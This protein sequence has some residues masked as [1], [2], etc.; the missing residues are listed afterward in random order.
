[1]TTLEFYAISIALLVLIAAIFVAVRLGYKKQVNEILFWLVTKAEQEFGS[2][3]GELKFAAVSAW[4]YERLPIA[5][6]IFFTVDQID[7]LIED[8]V[9]RMKLYLTTNTKA[10]KLVSGG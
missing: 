8:A 6:R 2:G 1:M 7:D 5:T 10:S 4:I 9:S 3:T